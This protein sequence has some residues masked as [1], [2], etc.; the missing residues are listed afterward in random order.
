MK[1][2]ESIGVDESG[3]GRMLGYG[4]MI[5]RGTGGT[6]ETLGKIEHPNEF[7]RQLQQQIAGDAR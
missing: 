4:S 2:V 5:V 3:L 7:K 6:V 1:K